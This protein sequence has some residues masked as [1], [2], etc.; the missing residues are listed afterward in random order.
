MAATALYI[1]THSP[2]E[3]IVHWKSGTRMTANVERDPIAHW[4]Y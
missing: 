3:F 2:R 4:N 1:E